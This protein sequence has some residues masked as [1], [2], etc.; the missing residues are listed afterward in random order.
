MRIKGY[1]K[2]LVLFTKAEKKVPIEH[3]VTDSSLFDGKV[4]LI[5]GGSGGIGFA[6]AKSLIESGCKVIISGT[7]ENKLS[8]LIDEINNEKSASLVI[9]YTKPEEF[10]TKVAE[11]VNIF[12]RVDIF[13][14]STGVHTENVDFWKMTPE[15]FDRVLDIDLKGAFFACQ[16]VG[17][18]MKENNIQG[19]I[20][21]V[22]SSRGSEPAWSPYGISKWG[23]KGMSLGLA[24]IFAPYGINVNTI[25]P[26]STATGLIGYEEGESIYS[27][28]N[29]A[30]RFIMPVEVAELAKIL[31]SDAGRMI[32]GETIHIAAGRGTYDIR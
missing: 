12:G 26:G 25:A 13:I 14:N 32:V 27:L 19:H 23:M 1:L 29:D 31:V 3:R 30:N 17:R 5:T 22:S 6:I 11:A 20:L 4:A 28:E 10:D 16:A 7:S 18:Y 2:R 9:D 8:K 24:K 21:L 15:E